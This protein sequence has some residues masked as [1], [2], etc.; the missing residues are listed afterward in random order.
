MIKRVVTVGPLAGASA[1]YYVTSVT[2]TSGTLLTLSHTQTPD[3]PRRLSVAYGN[4]GS[5]RTL[6]V[7]GQQQV[8][9]PLVTETI[10]IPSGG[11]GSPVQSALDYYSLTSILPGGGGFT[12][13]IT[14][15]TNGVA[16]T[17]WVFLDVD[18]FAPTALQVV[19]SG[20]VNYTVEQTLDD[21]NDP[22]IALGPGGLT[23]IPHSVLVSKTANAQDNYAY[24][25][26]L[27]RC[28]LNSGT[29]SCTFTVTQSA[30]PLRL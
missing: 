7:T 23:W 1:N 8:N 5:A 27:T 6:I 22:V 14:V 20:T 29:G 18:S 28:T 19:V 21:P 26:L 4:E 3:K 9:G 13:A 17:A 25:P 24:A 2:P 30:M 12:A 15:G 10:N 16:S 11:G